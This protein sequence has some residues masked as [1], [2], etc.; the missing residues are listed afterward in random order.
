MTLADIISLQR[1][2]EGSHSLQE[3]WGCEMQKNN[4]TR[5]FW[6]FYYDEE[7]FLSFHPVTHSWTVH[8]SSAQTLA[9]EVK[10]HW[11]S[12]DSPSKAQWAHVQGTICGR[13]QRYLNSWIAFNKTIVSPI[14]TVTCGEALED[15][16]NA[17]C[18][19]FGFYP[20][21]ISLTWLQDGEPLTRTHSSLGVFYHMGMGP[22]RP[23]CPPGFLKD[24][25]R[26]FPAMC[27]IVGKRALALCP[28]EG[29]NFSCR[30]FRSSQVL[31]HQQMVKRNHN[32]TLQLASSFQGDA[33]EHIC[34]EELEP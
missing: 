13:L 32:S 4:R 1:Q 8:P 28:V 12:D 7:P 11:K 25:S 2:K 6:D 20:W 26:D 5:G 15:T 10:K 19:A 16:I 34:P 17:T 24:R 33:V 27:D 23:A 30:G 14:V 18:W 9:M 22:T 31:N 21:I 29:D 3:S